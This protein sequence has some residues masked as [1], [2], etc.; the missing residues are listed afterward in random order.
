MAKLARSPKVVQL[1]RDLGLPWKGDC[2]ASI[3]SHALG[4]VSRIV[5]AAPI[6]VD[7]LDTLRR[8][9]ANRYRA[10]LEF[11]LSNDDVE[12]L[13][14]E[15][16][17]FHPHLRRRLVEEFLE[18]TT[19]GI[20]LERD[21]CDPVQ[22]RYLIVVDSRGD[23][24]ARSYF[25]AWHE[26]THLVVHPEQLHFPGFRRT[27]PKV[28]MEKDPLESVVDHVAG[29]LAF[30]ADLY[31]PIIDREIAASG[32]LT[33]EA[34]DAA[35]A[36]AAPSASLFATA[37]G[38][39]NFTSVPTLLVSVGMGVKVSERRVVRSPQKAFDFAPAVVKARLRLLSVTA[40]EASSGSRLAIRR[41]MR[42]PAGSVLAEAFG[43]DTDVVL[44]ADEDQSSWETSATGKLHTLP[45]HVQAIRR[46]RFVY[47]L[48]SAGPA[49]NRT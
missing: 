22:F 18:G 35:K 9:V 15:H 21:E 14:R 27:P 48:V 26:V 47:G 34:I 29:K 16:A 30:Y 4:V 7:S 20:T 39:I 17:G 11:I 19:E 31:Q 44:D 46:G 37:L 23:R 41:N 36:R 6:P 1:A 5:Q 38:S 2:L 13:A 25:T 43:C 45:I 28:E 33:F 3:R 42:V 40:N 10:R 32:A 24:A 49:R 12:R 8:V